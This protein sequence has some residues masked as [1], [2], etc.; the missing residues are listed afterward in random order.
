ADAGGGLHRRLRAAV[1]VRR[2]PLQ[3]YASTRIRWWG[4]LA[5]RTNG[6]ERQERAPT[7]WEHIVPLESERAITF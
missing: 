5:D 1:G 4:H 2:A 7:V 3:V 6:R